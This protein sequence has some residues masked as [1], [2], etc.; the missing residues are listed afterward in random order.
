MNFFLLVSSSTVNVRDDPPSPWVCESRLDRGMELAGRS[1]AACGS[2][3]EVR[4]PREHRRW[5]GG[6]YGKE[7]WVHL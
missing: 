3:D 5:S 1:R 4:Q 2:E 6:Q 7:D